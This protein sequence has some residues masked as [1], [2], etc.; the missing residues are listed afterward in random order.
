MLWILYNFF[1]YQGDLDFFPNAGTVQDGCWR[2]KWHKAYKEM[3]DEGPLVSLDQM[4]RWV[5]SVCINERE[6]NVLIPFHCRYAMFCSHYRAHEWFF[7]SVWNEQCQFVGVL[8]PSYAMFRRGE[9]SCEDIWS[10]GHGQTTCAL[11]GY[12][13]E[14]AVLQQGLTKYS[15]QGKWYLK[16]SDFTPTSGYHCGE[17]S[18]LLCQSHF[19]SS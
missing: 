11:M 13:A 16:T 1:Y 5:Q 19:S 7:E 17:S 14:Y 12:D 2:D 15:P 3:R 8:C 18:C 6:W 10:G 9:C 4:A